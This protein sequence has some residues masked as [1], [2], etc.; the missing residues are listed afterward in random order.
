MKIAIFHDYFDEIGGAEITLLYL[1]KGLDATIFTTNIDLEKIKELGFKDIKIK[2]IG[3]VPNIRNLKQ[4]ITRLK[5]YF[6]KLNKQD[7]YLFGGS[8]SI[9]FS[10]NLSPNLWYCFSP[11]RGLYDLRNCDKESMTKKVLKGGLISLD[12]QFTKR[13]KRIIAPSENIKSRIMKYYKRKS[14]V[15]Y[16]PIETKEFHYLK[17]NNYW[18]SLGRI[19]P[20]KRIEMQLKAFSKLPEEKLIIIGGSDKNHQRYLKELLNKKPENVFFLGEIYN[21]R[22]LLKFYAECKG[23]ITTAKDEDFG[24]TPVEAMASGKPVIAANEGGYK[25]TIIHGKTG[26]LINNIDEDK[27]AEKIKILS[28]ELKSKDI[29]LK[30]KLKCQKRA[31]EFDTKVF[32]EKIREEIKDDK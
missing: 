3:R 6:L 8:F 20:Y 18:L 15:I 32:I 28:K 7:L 30:Y 12:K 27:L 22:K 21:R 13:I 5:F 19:D 4:I 26:Y 17:N 9:Y 11:E 10:K 1:A 31:R 23:F 14:K 29:Q 24:M 25:E 16:S 2:S